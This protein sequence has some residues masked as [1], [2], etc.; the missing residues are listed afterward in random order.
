MFPSLST[1][2]YPVTLVRL[3]FYLSRC[4]SMTPAL[5]RSFLPM[6]RCFRLLQQPVPVALRRPFRSS[7]RSC[8]LRTIASSLFVILS[9]ARTTSSLAAV[10]T[11]G[12][13]ADGYSEHQFRMR[14][15]TTLIVQKSLCRWLQVCVTVHYCWSCSLMM[16]R[17]MHEDGTSDKNNL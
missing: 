2:S 12:S 5:R 14:V 10:W 17:T 8:V 1:L 16:G 4:P 3:H 6:H 13:E 11:M 9:R 15:L 7:E